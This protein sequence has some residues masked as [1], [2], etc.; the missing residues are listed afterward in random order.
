M[1]SPAPPLRTEA[2]ISDAE[3][4]RLRQILKDRGGTNTGGSGVAASVD[5][6]IARLDK[7][8]ADRQGYYNEASEGWGKFRTAEA[9]LTASQAAVKEL[10]AWLEIITDRFEGELEG[11]GATRTDLLEID[12]CRALTAKHGA[13]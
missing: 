11:P 12:K 2:A 8:E 4:G 5:G 9:A 7:A 3:L 6:L 10:V 13:S 1:T